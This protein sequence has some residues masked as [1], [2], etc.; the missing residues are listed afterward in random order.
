MAAFLLT[1]LMMN[2]FAGDSTTAV[3]TC[4]S[5]SR[6]NGDETY[7]TL[8]Y[9]GK[10][11]TVLNTPSPQPFVPMQKVLSNARTQYASSS[12]VMAKGVN[13][14]YQAKRQ[15][16]VSHWASSVSALELLAG[17]LD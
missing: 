12:A 17:E 8:K 9:G 11:A 10:M 7:L 5:Q 14:K 6:R 2:S 3:V 4:V 16:E 13:G 15:A 1:E